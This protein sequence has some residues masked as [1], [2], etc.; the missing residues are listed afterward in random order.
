[1]LIRFTR[2]I[3]KQISNIENEI[4]FYNSIDNTIKSFFYIC[5]Y[6]L[7]YKYFRRY[8]FF[9]NILAK[10][11]SINLLMMYFTIKKLIVYMNPLE[12]LKIRVKYIMKITI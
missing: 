1:M 12:L 5:I 8:K 10:M 11:K 3:K 7:D 9:T 6:L 2:E 4:D